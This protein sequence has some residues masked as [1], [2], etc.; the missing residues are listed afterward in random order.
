MAVSAATQLPQTVDHKGVAI[1]CSFGEGGDSAPEL[2]QIRLVGYQELVQDGSGLTQVVQSWV[3]QDRRHSIRYLLAPTTFGP[4]PS[5]S[6]KPTTGGF[7]SVM[8]LGLAA[9]AH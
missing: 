3:T 8:S 6:N 5:L 7:S 4:T 2:S 1:S 9:R